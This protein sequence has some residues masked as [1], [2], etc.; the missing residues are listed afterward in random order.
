M[1]KITNEDIEAEDENGKKKKKANHIKA[2]NRR[3]PNF[4]ATR[5]DFIH[6]TRKQRKKQKT[7]MK[8][9]ESCVMPEEEEKK[10]NHKTPHRPI[11]PRLPPA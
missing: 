11:I 5:P 1:K 7:N 3:T 10:E 6:N 8:T 9:R 4:N 2:R